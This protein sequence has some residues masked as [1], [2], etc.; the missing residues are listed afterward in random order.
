MRE[1]AVILPAFWTGPTGKQITALGKEARILA[2]YLLT[3]P[4]ANMIGIYYEP[5]PMIVHHTGI[6][7]RGIEGAMKALVSIDFLS[8]DYEREIVWV[9]EMVRYQVGEELSDGDK[10]V[11]GIKKRLKVLGK[12][13]YVK[14]FVAKYKEV[15]HL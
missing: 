1:Y 7:Q 8:Y 9:H 11:S 6:N 10:R 15:Y 2:A 13:P 14:E 3:G 4:Y 5:I 12:H